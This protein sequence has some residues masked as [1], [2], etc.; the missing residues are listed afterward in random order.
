MINID[1]IGSG[2]F[3]KLNLGCGHKTLTGYLNIDLR[4]D[5]GADYSTDFEVDGCLSFLPNDSVTDVFMSHLFEHIR[6]ING[7]MKEVY[8]VC[9]SGAKVRIIC[10]HWGHRSAYEDPTHCRFMTERSLM[11]FSR[12]ARCSDG[13]PFVKDYNFKTI[14][15]TLI[16]DDR[17]IEHVDDALKLKDLADKY[18]NVVKELVYDLEVIK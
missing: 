8:R 18:L 16:P 4:P 13:M 11:F 6:N 1:D 12:T 9:R 14:S 7:F 17:Y 3:T 2:K 5:C 15:L 10:P